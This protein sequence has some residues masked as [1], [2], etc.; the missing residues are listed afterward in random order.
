MR[1]GKRILDSYG[2]PAFRA[3]GLYEASSPYRHRER[4]VYQAP[5]YSVDYSENVNSTDFSKILSQA[6][7]LYS[8]TPSIK[9]SIHEIADLAVGDAW[10]AKYKGTNQRYGEQAEL[11]LERWF[12]IPDLLN[13]NS[14]FQSILKQTVIDTLRDGDNIIVLTSTAKNEYPK[15]QVIPSHRIGSRDEDGKITKGQ[16]K[17]F[18]QTNGVIHDINGVV[19][20]FHIL[21]SD[22]DKDRDVSARDALINFEREYSDQTRGVSALAAAIPIWQDLRDIQRWELLGIKHASNFAVQMYVP[23]EEIDDVAGNDS[24]FM[25]VDEVSTPSGATKNINIETLQGGEVHVW[26]PD[27]GAKLEVLDTKG[28][29]PGPNTSEYLQN[30]CIRQACLA[31]RWPIELTYDMNSRGATTKLVISKA[32][33]RIEDMQSRIIYPMWKRVITY[34][35]AKAIKSGYIEGADDW[36]NFQPTYPRTL[37]F[38]SARETAAD[39]EL[40][41]LG[42]TTGTQLAAATGYSYKDNIE[43][44]AKEL[45][46]ANEVAAKYNI[47]AGQL[48]QNTPNGN[49]VADPNTQMEPNDSLNEQPNTPN[50]I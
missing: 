31:L 2:R 20:A 49:T 25:S 35:L 42:I 33:R 41:K 5:I 6:R 22:P 7:D 47:N 14:G 12:E 37:V 17:G 3:S 29:R 45:A 1:N 16:Y 36:Y 44:K 27:S 50:S 19:I 43:E 40:Y 11:F 38:D 26:R 9:N 18:Y 30:H 21:G 28:G 48:I 34:V 32:Q 13:S 39:I 8:N 10:Y 24:E 46:W 15:I 4:T 23:P